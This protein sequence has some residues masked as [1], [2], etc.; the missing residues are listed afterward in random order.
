MKKTFLI[1]ILSLAACG[2]YVQPLVP[3][4]LAPKAPR[5][6]DVKGV[7]NGVSFTWASPNEDR[8]GKELK[9]MEG[10]DVYRKE[11]KERG[12]ETDPDVEFIKL[13]FIPDSSVEVRERMR[14]EARD[15]GRVGRRLQAPDS[16]TRFAYLDKDVLQGSTYLYKI[17]P[18]NQGG[19]EGAIGDY[20]KVIYSKDKSEITHLE[21]N[22]DIEIDQAS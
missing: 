2:R 14:Q 8:R 13:T 12:D 11:I 20:I 15:A 10:Y 5:A 3:E 17:V 22:S 1:L 21:A 9:D 19:V 18:T 6:L 4:V 16:F 7:E